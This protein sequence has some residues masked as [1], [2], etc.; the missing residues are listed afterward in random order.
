MK[1]DFS[2]F[3]YMVSHELKT[4]IRE[5]NLYA[6]FIA[7]DNADHLKAQSLEDIHA[8]QKICKNMEDMISC[9]MEYSKVGYKPMDQKPINLES[10]ICQC[11]REQRNSY[12]H[13]NFKVEIEPLPW[14]NG[15]LTL[16]KI[17]INNILSNSIKFT[18]FRSQ[19][20]L[21]IYA[22][23]QGEDLNLYFKDNGVGFDMVDTSRLLENFQRAH[24]E[25]DYEGNGIGL[26]TVSRIVSRYGGAVTISG[27]P[28][29]GCELCITLPQKCI[30]NPS[31]T[32]PHR[33]D[34]IKIGIIG[35]FSGI[36]SPEE[37]GKKAAYQ[38]AA[39]EINDM[40]GINGRPIQLLF[41]DDQS[42]T[43]RTR[44]LAETLTLVDE[45]DVLMGS[46]LS[47]S[48]DIMQH[49]AYHAKTLYLNTQ[50][51]EGGVASHYTFCLSAMPEQQ[52]EGMLQYLIQKY[53]QKCYIIAA[54]YN[55]GILSAEWA[56]YLTRKHGGEV[57]GIEYM[58]DTLQDF[59]PLIDRILRMK[60]DILFSMCV[61]PNQDQ[62]YVQ[63]HERGMNHI[64]NATT[65]VAAEFIQNVEL[66]PPTLENTYVMASFIEESRQPEARRFVTRFRKCFD[67]EAVPYMN[68]D[69]ETAYTSVYLYKKAV[70]VAGTTETEEVITALESG[71]I[72]FDGPGGRVWVRG[73]DHHTTRS[74]SCFRINSSHQAEEI[75]RT[76]AIHSDYIETMIQEK[77]GLSG[78]LKTLGINAVD[79]QYNMLL[80]KI[81]GNLPLNK[82]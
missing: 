37:K 18:R 58:D 12:A 20:R 13:Q 56:K 47:P 73:E 17:L 42:D 69:T 25:K 50:Q 76:E 57:V 53:G 74:V 75:F 43:R 33:D 2:D 4:P 55:Y 39:E 38:L 36:A 1:D 31:V 22:K 35:D 78:G 15:D 41:R 67:R 82:E 79:M 16:I 29:Q 30:L 81:R 10:L 40:G 27:R 66:A 72:Y 32:G 5:I 23:H 63:W 9:L 68:M 11:Y 45:V 59:N 7:E 48:R 3:L 52:M 34:L 80:N 60:P 54:D 6:E 77:T 24:N 61:F 26:A 21:K 46:T 51:T 65:Q 62:F 64:P 49:V 71:D 70:E 14:L 19:G 8:I 44:E 28:G